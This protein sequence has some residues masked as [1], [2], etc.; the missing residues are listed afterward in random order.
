MCKCRCVAHESFGH[1]VG[2]MQPG[3][4]VCIVWHFYRLSYFGNIKDKVTLRRDNEN[5]VVFALSERGKLCF[6]LC[7]SDFSQT[8]YLI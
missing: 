6:H 7:S 8:L 3:S 2:R 5:T 4:D 1:W